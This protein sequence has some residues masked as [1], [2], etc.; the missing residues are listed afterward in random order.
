MTCAAH[1]VS[2]WLKWCTAWPLGTVTLYVSFVFTSF[3]FLFLY[4]L[5]WLLKWQAREI[6][7]EGCVCVERFPFSKE[8]RVWRVCSLYRFLW[9]A[10]MLP[11]A[12]PPLTAPLPWCRWTRR[13]TRETGEK[14]LF[15]QPPE[16][17]FVIAARPCDLVSV[18]CL[19]P[20]IVKKKRKR[21]KEEPSVPRS[22]RQEGSCTLHARAHSASA[23]A[24]Q[25]YGQGINRQ[26]LGKSTPNHQRKW[27]ACP[28]APAAVRDWLCEGWMK[29]T[30]C[31]A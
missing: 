19:L 6:R 18:A 30:A 22:E 20:W 26:W 9:H 31:I 25:R 4:V 29:Q 17:L 21:K 10:F 16:K 12:E 1:K 14:K 13:E 24:N 7:Q 27:T 5:W 23:G 28:R 2:F 11:S 15:L 8:P 3:F